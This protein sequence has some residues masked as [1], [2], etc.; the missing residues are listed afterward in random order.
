MKWF[1]LQLSKHHVIFPSGR[2]NWKPKRQ[3]EPLVHIC[4]RWPFRPSA[5][6]VLPTCALVGRLPS[7]WQHMPQ[8]KDPME[9]SMFP[10]NLWDSLAIFGRGKFGH[11]EIR[12]FRVSPIQF[13]VWPPFSYR[14]WYTVLYIR[15]SSFSSHWIESRS[16]IFL[17][18][19]PKVS[20]TNNSFPN[21]DCFFIHLLGVGGT[22]LA[23]AP[24]C[25]QVL[26]SWLGNPCIPQWYSVFAKI[27]KD[28]E[29]ALAGWYNP[30]DLAFDVKPG[31]LVIALLMIDTL[32][33]RFDRLWTF[34]A[35]N[36][37]ILGLNLSH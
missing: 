20:Q 37:V 12:F 26:K 34:S 19:Q 30:I 21:K 3:M 31:T 33:V 9:S 32:L 1:Q 13:S 24:G 7:C 14:D 16:S 22:G 11:P 36:Q 8:G 15:Y 17:P 10:A 28:L 29:S 35:T 2:C 27:L 25:N 4:G 5:R 6:G 23:V 18:T